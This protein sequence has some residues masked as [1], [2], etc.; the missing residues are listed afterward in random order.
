M[1]RSNQHAII[2]DGT[3]AQTRSARIN[4]QH[5][6]QKAQH[7]YGQAFCHIV[8]TRKKKTNKQT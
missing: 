2:K 5:I 7:S 4:K 3:T 6:T 8:M 1:H